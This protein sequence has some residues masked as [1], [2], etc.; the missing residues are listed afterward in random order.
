MNSNNTSA[1]PQH[2]S[3][4]PGPWIELHG[5]IRT[6]FDNPTRPAACITSG[7]TGTHENGQ[8]L[9]RAEQ[10]ANARLIA[11]APELLEACREW[12][13]WGIEVFQKEQMSEDSPHGQILVQVR[14]AIAKAEGRA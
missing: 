6:R 9:P 2:A 1:E 8:P 13:E 7:D 4:T 5:L 10:E 12:L 14:A 3:H 11:V